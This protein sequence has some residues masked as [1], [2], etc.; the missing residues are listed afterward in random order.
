MRRVP[1]GRPR[2]I[3][4][5]PALLELLALEGCLVS[6]DAM[7]C[8]TAIAGQI[9]DQGAH[10]LLA[11][12]DNQPTLLAQIEEQFQRVG[13]QQSYQCTDWAASHNELVTYRVEVSHRLDWLEQ[14]PQWK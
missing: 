8:Q 12:K 1:R 7:G 5:I 13:A 14:V 9:I 11:V 2:E 3:T 4:A 10:Y 6:I